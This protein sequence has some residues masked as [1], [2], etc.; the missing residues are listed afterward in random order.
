VQAWYPVAVA[1]LSRRCRDTL[2]AAFAASVDGGAASPLLPSRL[3]DFGF[4]GC[5]GVEQSVLGGCAHLLSFDGTDTLS[6]AYYAQF[7]L[8]GGRPVGMSIPA[9]EHSVM[10]CWPSEREAIANMVARFGGGVF[11]TVMDSYDYQRALD[12]VV[13]AVAAEQAAAGGF[14]VLRPDSGVPED[15]VMAALVAADRAFGACGPER[16]LAP[17]PGPPRA[18]PRA[19]ARRR[20]PRPEMHRGRGWAWSLRE[21][22]A[23]R[24]MCGS[25]GR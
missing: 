12:E 1:T 16:R 11:A 24:R 10:T 15:A 14:W 7:A 25:R 8:N 4:R 21:C 23:A 20:R 18:A 22:L 3:H 5:T 17:G 6:A 19:R 2:A 9:T 13:P